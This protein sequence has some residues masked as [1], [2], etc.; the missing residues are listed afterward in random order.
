MIDFRNERD[1]HYLDFK[2]ANSGLFVRDPHAAVEAICADPLSSNAE[3][4]LAWIKRTSWGNYRLFCVRENGTPALQADCARSLKM[5]K[6]VL[7][8]VVRYLERRDF[9]R[10]EGKLLYPV[11]SPN[12]AQRPSK[13][14]HRGATFSA[15]LEDWKVAHGATFHELE[16]A[17]ATVKK[18]RLVITGEYKRFLAGQQNGAASLLKDSEDSKT[19]DPPSSSSEPSPAEPTTTT[20]P[21]LESLESRIVG[22]FVSA[23]KDNPTPKQMRAALDRLPKDARA[24]DAFLET[25]IA[26]MARV[27]HGGGLEW[28]MDGF[29]AAWPS[30]VQKLDLADELKRAREREHAD[31]VAWME[32]NPDPTHEPAAPMSERKPAESERAEPLARAKGASP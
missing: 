13:K 25:L 21:T 6:G 29:V 16:V 23:E 18:I 14:L 10:L 1:Q 3:R 4:V 26:K 12:P 11:L 5:N 27:K 24:G 31:A 7:S 2:A 30:I 20:A 9:V 19:L 22:V 28:A 15:F 8:K 17:E 32:A